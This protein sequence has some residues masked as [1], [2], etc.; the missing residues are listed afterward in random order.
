MPEN[1]APT[2]VLV[3]GA[4]ADASSWNAV[5]VPLQAQ[6]YEVLAPPNELRG[7]TSDAAYIASFLAQ[8]TSGPVVLVGHS[9]GGVVITNA[10]AQGGDVRALVYVDAFIPDEGENV[11]TILDGST[12]A[13]AVADPTTVLDVAGYPGAPEGVADVF[14]KPDTVHASFAQD[15]PEADR[16]VIVATQRPISLLANVEPTGVPAW[17]SIPSWAVLGTQDRVIPIDVQRRM[18]ERAGATITEVDASHVS[19]VSHPDV[20]LAAI[21]AAVD[22]VG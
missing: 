6:G 12:S 4:W 9:Y 3:H 2:I 17:R 10:G 18:A 21:Q 22:A 13:L 16:S 7:V 19:M 8:R 14:L 20:V 5:T 15:L 11:V 1:T